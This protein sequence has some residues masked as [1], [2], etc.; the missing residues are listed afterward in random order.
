[1]NNRYLYKVISDYDFQIAHVYEHIFISAFL[2]LIKE[3]GFQI[4]LFGWICG[5]IFDDVIMIEVGFYD[6]KARAL[7]DEYLETEFVVTDEMLAKAVGS[8]ACEYRANLSVD[9]E[10]IKIELDKIAE[11]PFLWLEEQLVLEEYSNVKDRYRSKYLKVH[12]RKS[13]YEEVAVMA[14]YRG[15]RVDDLA[16]LMRIWPIFADN[17]SFFMEERKEGYGFDTISP[18]YDKN[19][20]CV[21]MGE[22]YICRG[23]EYSEDEIKKDVE[24]ILKNIDFVNFRQEIEDYIDGFRRMS[25]FENIPRKIMD[26]I[27]LLVSRRK[28]AELF[29][30]EN[31]QRVWDRLEI[32]VSRYNLK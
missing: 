20:K 1:M 24:A 29:T 13:D 26:D 19:N 18:F 22:A 25:N 12:K 5:E 27:G 6:K 11:K 10:K 14:D 8:V 15:K 32:R 16:V 28:I 7:F 2:Q 17:I 4:G 30:A 9:L 3:K 21:T 23:G 31:V